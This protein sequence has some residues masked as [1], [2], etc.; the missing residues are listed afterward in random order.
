[1]PYTIRYQFS[2]NFNVAAEEAYLWYTDFSP[3]DPALM[4]QDK[5]KREITKLTS[6]ALI[7][8]DTF[9]T[10]KE[11]VVKEKLV[12]LYPERLTWVSTHL[13][14]PNKYS[15]F[16][17]EIK[18]ETTD[19][20]RLDFTAQHIEHQNDVSPAELMRL[21]DELCNYDVNVWKQLAAAMEKELKQ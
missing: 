19:S 7:L 20:S 18:A 9:G 12:Q 1:M 2:Q 10:G 14:G 15:Q 11:T 13:S 21:A 4:A 3:E 8:K 16:I 5:A 17:Y 6:A